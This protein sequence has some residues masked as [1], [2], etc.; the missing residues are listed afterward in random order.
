MEL[1]KE[2]LLKKKQDYLNAAEKFRLD[3]IANAGAADSMDELIKEME[4]GPVTPA[5]SIERE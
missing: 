4:A 2:Y 1:T 3:S 5:P